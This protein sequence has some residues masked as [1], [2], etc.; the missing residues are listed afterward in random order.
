MT[1]PDQTVIIPR[2]WEPRPPGDT[3][4]DPARAEGAGAAEVPS[5]WS[6]GD[7][8]G[9]ADGDRPTE[10]RPSDDLSRGDSARDWSPRG[11]CARDGPATGDRSAAGRDDDPDRTALIP[12][13]DRPVP[14]PGPVPD[15]W[16]ADRVAPG[17]GYAT[18]PVTGAPFG[19]ARALGTLAWIFAGVLTAVL[20]LVRLNWASMRAPEL[21]GWAF[22]T[23]PWH[24]VPRLIRD[25]TPGDV[26]YFILLKAWAGVFGRSDFALRVPSVLAM[27]AAV[28]LFA[29]LVTRLA[30]PRAGTLAG[31]LMALVPATSRYAQ[32]AGPAALTLL[33]AVLATLAL[34]AVF[35]RPSAGRLTGYALAVAL[36]GLGHVGGLVVVFAHVAVVLVM[37]RSVLVR[38]L[39]AVLVGA[40]PSIAVLVVCGAY[41]WTGAGVPGWAPAVPG[42]DLGMPSLAQLADDVAGAVMV[43][44]ALLALAMLAVSARKPAVVFTGWAVLPLV[45]MVPLV[46]L[47]TLGAEQIAVLTLP[48]WIGLAGLG[49]ARVRTMRGLVAVLLVGAIGIPAQL[50]IRRPDGHGQDSHRLADILYTEARPGDVM[51]FGPADGDGPAGRDIVYRYLSAAHRPKDVLATAPPGADGHRATPECSD[52]DDCLDGAARVWLI[53]VGDHDS[54]LTGLEAAKDGALRVRYAVV[55]SWDLTGASLT[56]FTLKKKTS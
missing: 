50:A 18:A 41:P 13:Q 12:R 52:V 37:K 1:D 38:W 14:M 34:V 25:T 6:S 36:M 5:G 16:D 23:T 55:Q 44:G 7:T 48:G 51:V 26:P 39:L 40:A 17:T 31:L 33:G 47:T 20:A 28:A 24:L 56:L 45:A 15:G 54:P 49:L 43:A 22:T 53:R 3:E 21:A 27:A 46:R 2:Q 8:A 11:D 30:G 4:P 9:D 10:G 35:D 32:E 29:V 19:R 42:V